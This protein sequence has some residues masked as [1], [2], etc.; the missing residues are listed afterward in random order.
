[1]KI[2]GAGDKSPMQIDFV[3]NSMGNLLPASKFLD[4][5]YIFLLF[6]YYML[7]NVSQ[8]DYVEEGYIL[9]IWK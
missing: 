7:F 9:Q 6:C 8:N 2:L 5:L 1:M 4:R 3:K